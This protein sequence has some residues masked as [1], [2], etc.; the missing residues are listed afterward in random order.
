[1]TGCSTAGRSGEVE[2]SAS[3]VSLEKYPKQV[4]RVMTSCSANADFVYMPVMK[5]IVKEGEWIRPGSWM[6]VLTPAP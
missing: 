1:M 6:D 4:A 5:F 3:K 2:K